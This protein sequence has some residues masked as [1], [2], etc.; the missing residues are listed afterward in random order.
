M[1]TKEKLSLLRNE[2]KANGLDAFVVFNADPHMSEYF[3]PYWE[4]R[5][6]ISSF[7]SSAGY[8]FITHDKA[9][10]WTDGRY[11]VQA[12]NELTG[13]GVDFFIEGTK[14]A[15]LSQEWLL[16]ELPQGA[17]VGCN[18]LCTPHNTW[19]LLSDTLKR[20]GITLVDKP[21]IEK[22]WKDRPKDDRKPIYVRAEKYTGRSTSDKLATLRGIMAEK[23]VTHFLVTALDDIAW[24]TNLRGNDVNFNPVFL[25]Y[26]C[27]TPKSATLFV[28]TKQCDDSVKAYLK[29][30]HIELKDYHDYFKELQKLKGETIL[31]SPDANQTIYNTV[32]EH[33]TL[34]IAP[35]PVQLLK[36]VKNETELEG[37]R[38]A[39]VKD[40]VALVNFFYWLEN[41]IGK[42]P[43]TE[44][45]LGDVMDKFRAEQGFL[46]NSFGKIIGYEGNGA[47][48]HYHAATNH[49][50]PMHAKGTVLID[51]GAHYIEGT[52]DITR[53]IPLG[54]FSEDFKRDYTLVMKAMITLSTTIFPAGTRGV[55]LDSIT[56]AIL[57]KN[58][59]DY[60]H[61]TGHGVGSYLCVHEGP[62]SIRKEMRD[63][64]ML[65]HMVCSNEPGIYCE[66][67]YGIRIENLVAVQKHSSNE[68]GDFYRLETLTL[69]PLDTRAVIVDML[70]EEERQWLNNYNQ[71]VEKTLSPLVGKEQQAWLK[72]RCK[73][74]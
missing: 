48:V 3:T 66:G 16:N 70:I 55:Q 25:A 21:L 31:L 74:I 32:G 11:L 13:T 12:K 46:A 35:S 45:S 4:E 71:W 40:G 67:R 64:P 44:H 63:V 17:K 41:N 37:F 73:A 69:C 29:E 42:T 51:S 30:Q 10:L 33:N 27:I 15:P 26:L 8:I 68:F 50:V 54:E 19:N 52:T 58:Q 43:L 18:G 6:W 38:K 5:K 7:D 39:M 22:I 9:V 34:H 59:R 60:G 24:V 36:A 28:D 72:E 57:W 53:V 47:I 1:T 65:E 56:R 49:E 14:D 62:Q 20:K 2:M 61:G 23:G